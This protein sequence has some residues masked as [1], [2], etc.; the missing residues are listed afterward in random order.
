MNQSVGK[1]DDSKKLTLGRAVVGLAA[2]ELLLLGLGFGLGRL[3]GVGVDW[4]L[5]AWAVCALAAMLAL[6]ASCYPR[7]VEFAMLRL[8]GGIVC[9]TVLPMALVVWGFKFRDPP[10]RP[11]DVLIL[12]L[13]YLVG[14]VAD[15]VL[16]VRLIHLP[17]C[18]GS[19]KGR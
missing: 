15:S 4:M 12:V 10:V 18:G 14:L 1:S 5:V 3:L 6:L 2:L 9:R 13:F 19:V 11:A 17:S 8:A 16:S 7:G